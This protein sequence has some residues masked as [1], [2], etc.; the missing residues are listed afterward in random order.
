[1][2]LP[3]AREIE[4]ATLTAWPALQVVHDG[5]WLWRGARGYT[6]R[7]NAIH[8]L[9]PADDA[10]A[11]ARLARMASLSQKNGL[12]PVFRVTPLTGPGVVAALDRAGWSQFEPSRVLAMETPAA[13]WP[14]AAPAR[15]LDH[16]D[17]EWREAQAEMAGYDKRTS[18]TLEALLSVM[19]CE[20]RGVLAYDDGGQPAAAALASVASGIG[21]FV[22]VVA[23]A[24]VRGQGYGRA[25]MAA[26]LNWTREAGASQAAIQVLA[27]NVPAIGLYTS[28][29]FSEVYQYHY[30]KLVP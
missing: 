17:P 26:A 8:C 12:P 24:S 7:A 11:D 23:R 15:V 27:G 3:S 2:G 20:T 4:S 5:L 14:L 19:A 18:E 21:I 30:R 13:D 22:N 16:L 1:M 9:D 10:D 6:K 29:G 25:V 28:L